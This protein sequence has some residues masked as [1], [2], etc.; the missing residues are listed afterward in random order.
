MN[1]KAL[2]SV[3]VLSTVAAFFSACGDGDSTKI[4]ICNAKQVTCLSDQ[5]GQVCSAD[6]TVNLPFQCGEGQRCC[7]PKVKDADCGE[8]VKAA[9]CVGVCTP[10]DT[11]C[12]SK[13]VSLRCSDDG[14]SWVPT[15]CPV[16]TGCDADDKSDTY[17]TCVNSDDPDNVVVVCTG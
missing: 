13:G 17:G 16:G 11:Q 15:D 5:G 14:R 10:G 3:A 4:K 12:G 8:D 2:W 7:D 6:G 9:T 1:T